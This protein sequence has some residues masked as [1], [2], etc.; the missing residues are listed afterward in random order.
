MSPITYIVSD[1]AGDM[2][3]HVDRL[4]V[5][6]SQ[7]VLD[8]VEEEVDHQEQPEVV[9]VAETPSTRVCRGRKSSGADRSCC[10]GGDANTCA[11][12]RRV[13]A[14]SSSTAGTNCSTSASDPEIDAL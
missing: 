12:S 1:G 11:C 5:A 9:T 10:S 2:K 13:R 14:E 6:Q 4:F 3:R 7:P 8:Q